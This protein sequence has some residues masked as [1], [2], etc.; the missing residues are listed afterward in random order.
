MAGS[1]SVCL[2]KARAERLTGEGDNTILLTGQ[3]LRARP[4]TT[5]RWAR[6]KEARPQE[7][8][9]AALEL[10]VERG[11]ASTRLDDVARRAGVSKGTV[12]LYF[13]SKE[14]LFKAV[15]REGMVPVLERGEQMA[16]THAGAYADLL[17]DLVRGWWELIGNTPYGGI[18]KLMFAECR[19]FP[20]I[21][22]FYFSEVMQRGH[23]LL[24]KVINRGVAA[25]E[26]RRLDPDLVT[27]LLIGPVVLLAVWRYSFDFCDSKRLD[28]DRYLDQHIDLLLH[29]LQDEV[30]VANRDAML[31]SSRQNSPGAERRAGAKAGK[32]KR[33]TRSPEPKR[34]LRGAS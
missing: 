2:K 34:P 29:G 15:I 18:P 12:Y 13:P 3:L 24:E 19:N 27:R 21:G 11:Y 22:Q 14:E 7:L 23:A 26:F 20:E 30:N 1:V 17:R 31:T 5:P 8:M 6:R 4:M 16:Q 25:G 9:S 28:P 33:Q 10:F 32:K